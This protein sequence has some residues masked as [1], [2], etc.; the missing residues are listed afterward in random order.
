MPTMDFYSGILEG[1]K[2]KITM[3]AVS[4]ED[5]GMN[6]QQRLGARH[7]ETSQRGELVVDKTGAGSACQ[8]AIHPLQGSW[9]AGSS[10]R[11]C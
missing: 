4:I 6:S 3:A 8:I 7:P 10:M 1:K 11:P 5:M 9:S 2:R